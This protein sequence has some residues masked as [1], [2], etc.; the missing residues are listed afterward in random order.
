MAS[1]LCKSACATAQSKPNSI[2]DVH[3]YKFHDACFVGSIAS[4]IETTSKIDVRLAI[5]HKRSSGHCGC[6]SAALKANVYAATEP[7]TAA[8]TSLVGKKL[9]QTSP[10]FSNTLES[11]EF[12]IKKRRPEPPRHYTVWITCAS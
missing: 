3:R 7:S 10:M 4:A 11:F 12:A 1:P 5:E 6:K 9:V 8:N 2:V